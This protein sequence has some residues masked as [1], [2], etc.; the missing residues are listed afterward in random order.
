MSSSKAWE[1]YMDYINTTKIVPPK[2]RK[3]IAKLVKKHM[4]KGDI[5]RTIAKIIEENFAELDID[6]YDIA[7]DYGS[8]YMKSRDRAKIEKLS[9]E[10]IWMDCRDERVRPEHAALNGKKF[11]W[12]KGANGNYPGK[13]F[14]CRCIARPVFKIFEE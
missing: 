9:D 7:M 3:G 10:F 6:Y 13:D 11:T 2:Y 5:Y 14:K 1:Y 4:E 8:K 12:E